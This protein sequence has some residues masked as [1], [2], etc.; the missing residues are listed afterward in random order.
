MKNYLCLIMCYCISCIISNAEVRDYYLSE[1]TGILSV[2][3]QTPVNCIINSKEQKIKLD[4]EK[5]NSLSEAINYLKENC[6]E[7]YIENKDDVIILNTS[8]KKISV[9]QKDFTVF[10]DE[11]KSPLKNEKVPQYFRI[12]DN[13]NNIIAITTSLNS[14]LI[15]NYSVLNNKSRDL[16]G[17]LIDISKISGFNWTL[18]DTDNYLDLNNYG[19]YVLE[20][21]IMPRSVPELV[22][23]RPRVLF[24][25]KS[26]YQR[27]FDGFLR[28]KRRVLMSKIDRFYMN[29]DSMLRPIKIS[30]SKTDDQ[31]SIKY[32][33]ALP[34]NSHE[35]LFKKL[36]EIKIDSCI[37]YLV[38]NFWSQPDNKYGEE[39]VFYGKI[40]KS[41]LLK[42]ISES[43]ID[44][45]NL[46]YIFDANFSLKDFICI[47][48][49]EKTSASKVLDEKIKS[50]KWDCRV[51]TGILIDGDEGPKVL[52]GSVPDLIEIP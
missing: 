48:E 2:K 24:K 20:K 51:S 41:Q 14:D 15:K 52:I 4:I 23:G 35:L 5:F 7:I 18:I 30:Y 22:P 28:E 12:M 19:S 26:E 46:F 27:Y 40:D 47:T 11:I 29:K 43:K 49:F 32:N 34:K 33:F 8:R 25:Q 16:L 45:K 38:L 21:M 10:I 39:Y 44:S 6:P 9:K 17:L 3:F 50:G 1:I 37:P 36:N 42:D 13:Q 31:I